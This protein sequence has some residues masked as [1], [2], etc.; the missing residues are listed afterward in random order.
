MWSQAKQRLDLLN[1]LDRR[2]RSK[3]KDKVDKETR[4][5]QGTSNPPRKLHETPF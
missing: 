1:A 3:R 4:R 5:R 2:E